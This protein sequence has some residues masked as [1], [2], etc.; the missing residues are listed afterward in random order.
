MFQT[1]AKGLVQ[2]ALSLT[3]LLPPRNLSQAGA[4]SGG[5]ACGC[6]KNWVQIRNNYDLCR[7]WKVNRDFDLL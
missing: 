7:L 4:T 2:R 3:H 5:I 6:K 1:G